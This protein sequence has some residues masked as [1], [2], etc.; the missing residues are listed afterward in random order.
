MKELR[1]NKVFVFNIVRRKNLKYYTQFFALYFFDKFY[2]LLFSISRKKYNQKRYTFSIC[3]IFKNEAPYMKEWIEYYLLI[4]VDHFYLYNNNSEDDYK[5]VLQHYIDKGIVTLT[6]WPEIP[7]QISSYKHWYEN[8]RHETNWCSFL[9]LDEFICPLKDINIKDW[10]KKHNKYPL[11]AIYWKM[12]GTSGIIKPDKNKLVIEQ[13]T[14]SWD[15]FASATKVIYNTDYDIERFFTSMMHKFN[16]RYKGLSIPPINMFGYFINHWEIHRH[17]NKESDIQCNHYW[18]KSYSEYLEKHKRGDAVW[19]EG[20]SRRNNEMFL[21]H[22]HFNRSMDYNIQRFLIELKLK[23][24]NND[25][26]K[27]IY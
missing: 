25:D 18:S 20:K 13:Y 12:F 2:R 5:S 8:Y 23:V 27:N 7:G 15:K 10:L 19:D 17:G 9:D 3:S 22:E 1:E 4:G 24:F 21:W 26:K 11:Y 6:E 14:N 16:V